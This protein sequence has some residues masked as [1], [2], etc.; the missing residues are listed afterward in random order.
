MK[1]RQPTTLLTFHAYL[2][3]HCGCTNASAIMALQF[4]KKIKTVS[5]REVSVCIIKY[6]NK[7]RK[8]LLKHDRFAEAE[9]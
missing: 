1:N 7:V 2:V 9:Q 3:L 4:I 8:R 6:V 5:K